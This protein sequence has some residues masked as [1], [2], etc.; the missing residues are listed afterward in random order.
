MIKFGIE[1]RKGMLS[2]VNKLADAVVVTMGPKGRNVC[3]E[4][5][6][7]AP[8]ITKDGVSV[9]KEIELEDPWENVGCRM[10]REVASKTSEDSGDGTT[11]STALAR[12]MFVQGIHRKRGCDQCKRGP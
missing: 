9:A 12:A 1:A 6:F 2:G 11:T 3:M 10:I 5:A 8:L 4:K 7:G